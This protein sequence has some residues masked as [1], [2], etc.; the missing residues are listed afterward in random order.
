MDS[1]FEILNSISD[2]LF[3]TY[4]FDIIPLWLVILI[5]L[6]WKG[7]ERVLMNMKLEM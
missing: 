2:F 7:L 4:L 1:L 6:L 5:G 3:N